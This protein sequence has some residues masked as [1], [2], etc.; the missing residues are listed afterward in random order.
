MSEKL[1]WEDIEKR[2]NQEWVELVE[3]EW[4]EGEINPRSGIVRVHAKTRKEFDTLIMQDPPD[5]AALVYVGSPLRRDD[6]AV[7]RGFSKVVYE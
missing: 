3:Y 6:M 5:N 7:T 1:T 2:Y 4:P